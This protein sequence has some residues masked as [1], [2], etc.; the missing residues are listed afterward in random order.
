MSTG[1]GTLCCDKCGRPIPV[2][3]SYTNIG[4]WILCGLCQRANDHKNGFDGWI[5][6]WICPRCG[7]VH[8]YLSLTCDCNPTTL[9]GVTYP[10]MP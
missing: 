8:S 9:T 5:D 7:K 4:G 6:G 1:E 3:K 10:I 2:G